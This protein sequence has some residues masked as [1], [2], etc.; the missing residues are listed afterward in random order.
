MDTFYI[1]TPI[2]YVNANP[3]LGHAYTTILADAVNRF[4]RLMGK[5]TFF[6]TGTDEHGEK[7]L[8]ASEEKGVNPGDYVE[9]VSKKFRDLWP[10]LDIEYDYFIRT[11]YPEH[12][13]CVQKILQ[14]VY[15]NGDIYFGEYGGYYCHGCEAFYTDRELE[16]GKCPDHQKPLEYIQEKN[17][18]FRMS[19]YQDWLIE[20][21]NSDPYFI[22]PENFKNEVLA[23]LRESLGD[24]CISRP[25]TRL[26]WGIELPF[27]SDYVTYVWF[28]ALLNYISALGWPEDE[29]FRKFWPSAH[30]VVAK[31]ILKP[32]AIFWPTML[33]S[34]GLDLYKG[35]RVHGYWKVEEAKMS[36]SL[37]NIVEPLA[38]SGKYGTS[39]F[40]YFLMREMQLGLDGSFSEQ[41]LVNRFNA[42]LANDL[43]N[44]FNRALAMLHKYFRGEVPA[45]DGDWA[46][47]DLEM[48]DLGLQSFSDYID[49]YQQFRV[50]QALEALWEFIRGLNKYIDSTAPW[51]LNKEGNLERLSAVMSLVFAGLRK[52]ALGVWPVMPRAAETMFEQLGLDFNAEKFDLLR[53]SESFVQLAAGTRVA[54][55]SNL[56]PRQELVSKDSGEQEKK[57]GAA[58]ENREKNSQKKQIDIKQF[59]ELDLRIGYVVNAEN[60]VET[61]KLLR[62]DV[63]V[64]E[65]RYRQIVAGI[66]E[67]YSPD[68][69]QHTQVVVVCN[70]KPVTLKGLTSEGM[71]LSAHQ[72]P[73]L[74]LLSVKSGVQPGSKVG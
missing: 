12:K 6:L 35:L 60:V 58:K 43:G 25:K 36:K 19:A 11:T 15:D 51:Q 48:I 49:Y 26:T 46:Q 10:D 5:E 37:G 23:M 33:K 47:E 30:H 1:T 17:Y 18:F 68:D 39:A 13:A 28:D 72:D 73:G 22:Q 59:Q 9:E 55:K 67:S 45:Y 21:I 14:Q 62:L 54:K 53:E 4:Q 52:A 50:A 8:Q 74:T 2:Y 44:L 56:F 66:A 38:M 42:D 41:G 20:H 65:E 71:I 24:L 32:H 61:D 40:R 16:D 63:D 69:I 7:I 64:G 27:D 70:L 3:H 34:A 57:K 31:D 29:N